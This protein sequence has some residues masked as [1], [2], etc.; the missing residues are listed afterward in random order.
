MDLKESDFIG[1]WLGVT[2]HRLSYLMTKL[3]HVH[4]F[5]LTHEQ[6]VLLS[7]ISCSQGISQ[8]ELAVQLDRDKTSIA[9]SVKNL[10]M[11]HKVT[12]INVAGDK[13]INNLYLT[14]EGKQVLEDIQP[15]FAE[16]ITELS[17]GIS[18]DEMQKTK[19]TLLKIM[20]R[21]GQ[22]ENKL[23]MQQ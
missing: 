16:F 15:L 14:K 7:N 20:N 18:E 22:M 17:E 13:R 8:K 6:L 21:V 9:R 19:V 3:L 5:D 23:R 10:E 11:K 12:R 2:S 1:K 4:G